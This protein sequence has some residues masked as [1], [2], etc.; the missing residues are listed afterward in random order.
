M[1]TQVREIQ[2][3]KEG[4]ENESP[5]QA[6]LQILLPAILMPQRWTPSY[7]SVP[8]PPGSEDTGGMRESKALHDELET[9]DTSPLSGAP[10]LCCADTG[11]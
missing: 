3:S 11:R 8:H 1:I 10:G 2:V 9:P 7:L 4:V 6:A 5:R